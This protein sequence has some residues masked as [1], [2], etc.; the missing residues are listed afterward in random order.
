MIRFFE[1]LPTKSFDFDLEIFESKSNDSIFLKSHD[2]IIWFW[3]ENFRIKIK[4]F[5]LSKITW[6]NY[7]I[8][9]WK[10]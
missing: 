2:K 5:D 7:L 1:N 6:Q 3:F 10:F 9:I 8:L 4:W